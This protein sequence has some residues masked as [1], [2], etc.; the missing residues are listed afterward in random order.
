MEVLNKFNLIAAYP[1]LGLI[2]LYQRTLSPDH[3]P[4]KNLH[5]FGFCK[6]YPTCSEY[7][8]IVLAKDGLVGLPKVFVRISKCNPLTTP[9]VDTP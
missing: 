2:W 3:G 4:Y 9:S 7:A 5:P 6:F 8:R 1:L